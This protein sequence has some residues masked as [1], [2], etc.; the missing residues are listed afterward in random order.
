M[1]PGWMVHRGSVQSLLQEQLLPMARRGLQQLEI[2]AKDIDRY[3]GV[4]EARVHCGQTGAAWQRACM[5]RH[6]D[7][8]TEMTQLY[9]HNQESKAPVHEWRTT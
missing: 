7:D 4:I 9:R 5:A 3:L 2:D 8:L 1:S 6:G